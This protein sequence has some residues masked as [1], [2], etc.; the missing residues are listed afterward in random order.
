LV[1]SEGRARAAAAPLNER[2]SKTRT[3]DRFLIGIAQDGTRLRNSRG[4]GARRL[5]A[6]K[7]SNR[8][9]PAASS[10]KI[11]QPVFASMASHGHATHSGEQAGFAARR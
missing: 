8:G 2:A 5:R 10:V 3:V 6:R 7:Q 11:G 9:I 1:L 4:A